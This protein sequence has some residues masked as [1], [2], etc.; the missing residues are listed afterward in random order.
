MKKFGFYNA[1]AIMDTCFTK[2]VIRKLNKS[3]LNN[4]EDLNRSNLNWPGITLTN[5]YG[6]WNGK[7]P[8]LGP[9]G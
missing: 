8:G 2:F 9:R 7:L 4:Q 3:K 5:P 6:Q 1:Y